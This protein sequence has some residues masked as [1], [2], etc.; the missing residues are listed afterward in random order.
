MKPLNYKQIQVG[1]KYHIH[2]SNTHEL[3]GTCVGI[4]KTNL[5]IC[6]SYKIPKYSSETNKQV[7][8]SHTFQTSGLRFDFDECTTVSAE[9]PKSP[10]VSFTVID[11]EFVDVK[12]TDVI[13]SIK[14]LGRA[15]NPRHVWWFAK[16]NMSLRQRIDMYEFLIQSDKSMNRIPNSL[17]TRIYEH[18]ERK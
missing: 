1:A 6:G 3:V 13:F 12:H 11:N 9:H 8:V 10:H 18:V 17:R 14:L 5:R 16:R 2:S 4:E 7:S 15:V